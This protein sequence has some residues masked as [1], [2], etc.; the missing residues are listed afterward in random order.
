MPIYEFECPS[1]GHH[2]DHLQKLSDADP[3][4][5]VAPAATASPAR[6]ASASGD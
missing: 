2:F 5:A 4:V 1:C 3:T 6:T